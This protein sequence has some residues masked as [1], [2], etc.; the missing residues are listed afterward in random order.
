VTTVPIAEAKA[1]FSQLIQ[2]VTKGHDVI[3]TRGVGR[4]PVAALIPISAYRT[5][6]GIR[7]GLAA[8]WTPDTPEDPQWEL[9]DEQFLEA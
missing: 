8:A 6:Q 9:S 1:R 4:E 3:V 7:L 2:D 5:G